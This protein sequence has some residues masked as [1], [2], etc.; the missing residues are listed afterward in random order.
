MS[1]LHEILATR[2]ARAFYQVSNGAISLHS[3][4]QLRMLAVF[5]SQH[6]ALLLTLEST[7][8]LPAHAEAFVSHLLRSYQYAPL[9]AP[10]L[11]Q[12]TIQHRLRLLN[13][14]AHHLEALYNKGHS[15]CHFTAYT[16]HALQDEQK[17]TIINFIQSHVDAKEVIVTFKERQE[18]ISG[19]R[20]INETMMWERSVQKTLLLMKQRLLART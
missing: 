11:F 3:I 12:L 17:N 4:E 20:I 18:L 8:F 2:Y 7:H 5:F 10:L 6:P 13:Q 15:R 16:S 14:I 9:L 19:I 1:I